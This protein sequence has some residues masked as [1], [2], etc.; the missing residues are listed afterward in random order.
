M[1]A[2][3]TVNG[4]SRRSAPFPRRV[5]A[6][7]GAATVAI[8][9][10]TESGRMGDGIL[11]RAASA[12]AG[13]LPRLL[14]APRRGSPLDGTGV[15][16]FHLPHAALPHPGVDHEEVPAPVASLHV[17][18]LRV[19][20]ADEGNVAQIAH[21]HVADGEGVHVVAVHRRLEPALARD[22]LPGL[23]GHPKLVVVVEEALERRA[24]L[25]AYR[26]GPVG[27]EAGEHLAQAGH[28]G[29]ARG[30]AGGRRLPLEGGSDPGPGEDSQD[31]YGRHPHR[32]LRKRRGA[33]SPEPP[34][35]QTCA[36]S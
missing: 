19:E 27:L 15:T 8:A 33:P 6:A 2:S 14:A 13:A 4:R 5:W 31:R 25:P 22:R 32:G 9:I 1:E 29:T 3:T 20:E 26:R 34:V 7:A 36:L 12:A 18:F 28:R 10:R 30:A 16:G 17:G 21:R 35:R 11:T 23:R 24:V